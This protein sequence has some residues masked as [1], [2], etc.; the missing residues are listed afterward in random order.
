MFIHNGLRYSNYGT[1]SDSE[2]PD[3]DQPLRERIRH[4]G[5]EVSTLKKAIREE[6]DW[7]EKLRPFDF[8]EW[9]DDDTS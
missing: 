1:M 3:K 9:E 5:D 8:D 7:R 2:H 6:L 4:L